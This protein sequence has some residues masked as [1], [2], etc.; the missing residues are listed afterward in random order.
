M[1]PP[2]NAPRTIGITVLGDYI[3]SDGIDTVL[4]NLHG[5]GATAV[6]CNPTVTAAANEGEGSFQPPI[7]AG[8]S[9]REF[10]RPLFGRKSLW[11]RSGVSYQPRTEF[12]RDSPYQPRQPN[13]LTATY[14]P[15]IGEF[16]RQA[17]ASGLKVY[18][19][20][21]AVQPSGLRD[22]D[23]PRLP[24]G[25][26]P[27]NRMADTGSLASP[28]IRAYNRAYARDLLAEYPELAG[29]RI[30]WPEYPCY[31]L[32]EVFQDFGPHVAR[33]SANHGI[34]F[35]PLRNAA[36]R[37][38]SMLHGGLTNEMLECWLDSSQNNDDESIGLIDRMAAD[39]PEGQT[40]L[41][42]KAS[43]SQDLLAD[44]RSIVSEFGGQ[45]FELS[46][47]AFMWPYSQVTGFD[48]TTS[49]RSCDSVSPKLYTM[50]WSLMM[51]FWG[52][53][54]LNANPG[55]DEAL[56]VRFLEQV[57]E[58]TDPVQERATT[59]SPRLLDT[60]G[61]PQPDEPH[62]VSTATQVQKL[63]AVQSRLP[64]GTALWPLVHGYGP[65]DDF[66]R[67][68][69]LAFSA[70]V[71]GVWINRYGY[72]SDEKLTHIKRRALA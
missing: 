36:Q 4:E 58:L 71:D 48:F 30:D 70:N 32:G 49:Q 60:Y 5:A 67:R 62:P 25:R 68:L 34:A 33:W 55:L 6:A 41:Q 19:Q 66:A 21:A 20:L 23:R 65:E 53:E 9:V 28:A 63:R 64:G 31:T 11:V 18:M 22:E 42:L 12:Y 40:I 3:L 61:Y 15:L 8:A 14:G 44:W 17:A 50:H 45:D 54:I 10:D 24:D 1:N 57:M 16:V 72:L 26:I 56:L 13:D 69:D 43:L 2:S 47:H 35:A 39:H 7:D 52:R 51:E 27:V 59:S 29:F 37:W 38:Y 46:G